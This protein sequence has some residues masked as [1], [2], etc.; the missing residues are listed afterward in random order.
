MKK[1]KVLIKNIESVQVC[2]LLH[3]ICVGKTGT[4]TKGEMHVR[5][6]QLIGDKTVHE[7]KW[8]DPK[9]MTHF[10]RRMKVARNMDLGNEE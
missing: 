1:D 8:D 6:Y 4:L 2:A 5:S 7:N 3:E 10:N 9:Y